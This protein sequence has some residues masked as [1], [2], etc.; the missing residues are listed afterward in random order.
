MWAFVSC[1]KFY[2]FFILFCMKTITLFSNSE[3]LDEDKWSGLHDMQ[4]STC[5]ENYLGQAHS[6]VKF[7]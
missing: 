4:R 3:V 7:Q 1:G 2:C 5:S 6:L